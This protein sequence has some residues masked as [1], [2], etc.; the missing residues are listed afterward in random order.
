MGIKGKISKQTFKDF[1]NMF[2]R[3]SWDNLYIYFTIITSSAF[4]KLITW[5]RQLEADR[6]MKKNKVLSV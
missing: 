5:L 3:N 1:K 4:P 6:I 2:K